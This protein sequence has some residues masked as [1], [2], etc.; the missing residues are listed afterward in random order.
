MSNKISIHK[1]T[2]EKS[3]EIYVKHYGKILYPVYQESF[4]NIE[5]EGYEIELECNKK[6]FGNKEIEIFGVGLL[7]FY[8][9]L[10]EPATI[11]FKL[12]LPKNVGY[13]LR[14]ALLELDVRK[15]KRLE[16][17]HVKLQ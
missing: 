8:N 16:S 6:G 12:Y 4:K 2:I 17:R 11:K 14:D 13:T 1:T 10:R 3:N 7:G 5:F 15:E 9:I